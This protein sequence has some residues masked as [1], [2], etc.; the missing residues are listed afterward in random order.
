MYFT[1]RNYFIISGLKNVF[2]ELIPGEYILDQRKGVGA[3]VVPI[4]AWKQEG[5]FVRY[6]KWDWEWI[7]V[8][9]F[10]RFEDVFEGLDAIGK[11]ELVGK[12]PVWVAAGEFEERAEMDWFLLDWDILLLL[13][14]DLWWNDIWEWKSSPHY[15]ISHDGSFFA[16][17]G[18]A[19][20]GKSFFVSKNIR[21]GERYAWGD[22]FVFVLTRH[23]AHN[24][25]K[26]IQ[27]ELASPSAYM[28][29]AYAWRDYIFQTLEFGTEAE[30]YFVFE[31]IR[32]LDD[33]GYYSSHQGLTVWDD[34]AIAFFGD[35][36]PKWIRKLWQ[37]LDP[38]E[39][40]MDMAEY[41]SMRELQ[42]KTKKRDDGIIKQLRQQ[43]KLFNGW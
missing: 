21:G 8:E 2:G 4:G 29:F 28:F 34:L 38:F 41:D 39:L 19:F 12:N 11:S 13:M 36:P 15:I 26:A 18:G 40:W 35:H 23:P 30:I 27:E 17:H 20:S 31:S 14:D 7:S 10:W 32:K 43:G 33:M 22:Y 37:F 16:S 25:E 6:S 1:F 42:Q 5:G 9:E 3:P 24:W